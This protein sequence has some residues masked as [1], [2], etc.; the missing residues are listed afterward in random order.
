MILLRRCL[1]SKT[2]YFHLWGLQKS[3]FKF[4]LP[5]LH[6]STTD[7]THEMPR[8]PRATALFLIAADHEIPRRTSYT[9]F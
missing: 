2:H 3:L 9:K 1:E 4:T 6:S 8:M 7:L 5:P